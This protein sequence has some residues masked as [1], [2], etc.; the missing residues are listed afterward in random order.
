MSNL[1]K[2]PQDGG[3]AIGLLGVGVMG[4]L[5]FIVL[6]LFYIGYRIFLIFK[7]ETTQTKIKVFLIEVLP[8]FVAIGLAILIS[9]SVSDYFGKMRWFE[10]EMLSLYF[11]AV[12][13]IGIKF[14][15]PYKSMPRLEK[16]YRLIAVLF[17]EAIFILFAW[18]AVVW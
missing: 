17:F 14:L 5:I 8:I 15:Q 18:F 6:P 16:M 9:E 7:A 1:F 4:I 11:Y 3:E 2:L 13:Y 12:L 10:L